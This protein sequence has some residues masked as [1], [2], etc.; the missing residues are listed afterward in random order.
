MRASDV[1]R[2]V[3][4]PYDTDTYDC[5]DLVAQVQRELFGRDVQMP[6]RRPRG[7]AG[8]PPSVGCRRPTRCQLPR[9]SMATWC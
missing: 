5:A 2:F 1:D 9:P 8:K 7:A 3:G 4:I 6:A